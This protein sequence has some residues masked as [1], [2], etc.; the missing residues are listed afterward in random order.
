M[1]QEDV[2]HNE[3][4]SEEW[5]AVGDRATFNGNSVQFTRS[6]SA[7]GTKLISSGKHEWAI[8][9]TFPQKS[10]QWIGVSTD[11][12]ALDG[13]FYGQAN[14][15]WCCNSCK[16]M[17]CNVGSGRKRLATTENWDSGDFITVK[18]DLD[19]NTI[20]WYKNS[21]KKPMTTHS[22]VPDGEYK[23]AVYAHQQNDMFAIISSKSDCLPILSIENQ[24]FPII[25]HS[26]DDLTNFEQKK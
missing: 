19:T 2:K 12:A 6:G 23:I 11:F 3:Y 8:K 20:S 5:S 16:E 14:S 4:A 1:A 25:K 10:C 22:G 24:I 7:Y 18:L 21:N 9:S 15:F 13:P 26:M 17:E